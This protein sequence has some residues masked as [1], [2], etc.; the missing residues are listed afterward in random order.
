MNLKK[1]RMAATDSII[2]ENIELIKHWNKKGAT[3][4]WMCLPE[5]S[6]LDLNA[7]FDGVS[8]KYPAIT[9][10][11]SRGVGVKMDWSKCD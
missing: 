1:E 6:D 8:D 11:V 3:V 7:V 10:K 2:L 5:S 9:F 4:S